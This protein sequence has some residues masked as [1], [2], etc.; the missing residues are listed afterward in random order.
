M[1]EIYHD[2]FYSVRIYH[3][4]F[5]PVG[6]HLLHKCGR[7]H[8]GKWYKYSWCV[9]YWK[10][11]IQF[12]IKK[13]KKTYSRDESDTKGAR[14]GGCESQVPTTGTVKLHQ[15]TFS[16]KLFISPAPVEPPAREIR[17]DI[18]ALEGYVWVREGWKWFRFITICQSKYKGRREARNLKFNKNTEKTTSSISYKLN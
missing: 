13:K 9:R 15:C 5:Y 12:V 14:D 6:N 2:Y 1:V 4:Y 7:G 3:D 16:H 17:I 11:G 18:N 10:R 8:I